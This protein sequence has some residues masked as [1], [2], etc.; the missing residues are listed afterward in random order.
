[1][2]K[3]KFQTMLNNIKQ[4]LDGGTLELLSHGKNY[5]TASTMTSGLGL[6]SI[7]I[8]TRLLS[9]SDYGILSIFSTLAA[10][11]GII[12]GLGIRGAVS[13]YYYEKIDDFGSFITT[14]TLFVM[15]IGILLS[16]VVFLNRIFISDLMNIPVSLVILAIFIA[17][18]SSPYGL[19]GAFLQASKQSL[20]LSRI[21][22][23]SAVFTLIL[24]VITT[25]SL[26]ENLYL[27]SVYSLL[28]FSC[29]FF[30]FSIYM[31]SKI[32]TWSFNTKHLKYS[33]V[34]G[35]PIIVHLLS[36]L[37]LN[38]FDQIMIN[39]MI[40]SHET[41]LYSF[42]YKV[43]MLFQMVIIGLNQA[44]IP[45]FYEKLRDAKYKEIEDTAKK[46]TYL[47]SGAALLI[48]MLGPL[49]I[50]ILAP[51][52]YSEA[53]SLVPVIIVGFLFQYFYFMYIN[54]AFYAKKTSMIAIIT[55]IAGLI[56]IGL[57][58]WLIPIFGYAAA[59]W[60]TLATYALFFFMQYINVSYSIKEIK[61][62]PLKIVVLPCLFS[63]G[64][65]MISTAISTYI[66]QPIVLILLQCSL[67]MIYLI[68]TFK[69]MKT[70]V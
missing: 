57:N 26:S 21:S 4:K 45:I 7:P 3:I 32:G 69:R 62:I 65:I 67:V 36:G 44:W 64:L 60:T 10:I 56:N 33:L 42:A 51:E 23:V 11:L 63:M 8:M 9:P 38:S 12:F 39:K 16:I 20:L 22:I 30:I 24:T 52:T 15:G 6:I 46:F 13:R 49:L 19:V 37:I 68:P 48:T 43:G 14:N 41:G 58:Y 66:H 18:M 70:H 50:I 61:K 40:G 1:V 53:L 47:V 5:V 59:A 35:L 27:G 28:T 55:L 17:W 25:V 54:Y 29:M 2:I 34:F 31:I